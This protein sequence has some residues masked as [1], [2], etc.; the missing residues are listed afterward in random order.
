[1][2]FDSG[3][4]ACMRRVLPV[5]LAPLAALLI[6][7]IAAAQQGVCR[8]DPQVWLTDGT[9]ISISPTIGDDASAIVAI[10]YEIHV[11]AGI[12]ETQVVYTGG[13]LTGK[14]LVVILPDA[15]AGTYTADTTVLDANNPTVEV[16]Y[17]VITPGIAP[18]T[19]ASANGTTIAT[20]FPAVVQ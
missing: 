19:T 7:G 17:Q 6:P 18:V 11:P 4:K 8:T 12:G 5:A 20:L 1:M 2:M 9:K 16:R 10:V 3:F 14:E 15:P 13:A